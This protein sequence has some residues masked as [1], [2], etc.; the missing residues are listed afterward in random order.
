MNSEDRRDGSDG[1]STR[2]RKARP[3]GHVL[4]FEGVREAAAEGLAAADPRT[5]TIADEQVHVAGKP[6]G[7]I[8]S[9]LVGRTYRAR[10]RLSA[11][12]YYATPRIHYDEEREH[13]HPFSYH[14]YAEVPERKSGRLPVRR[15]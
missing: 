2:G 4:A 8:W 11:H 5:V 13:G 1:K 14:V 3:R 10:K 7:M 9:D 15:R 6:A 12:G